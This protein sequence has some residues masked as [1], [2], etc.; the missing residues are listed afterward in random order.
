MIITIIVIGRIISEP[1]SRTRNNDVV[2]T[3]VSHNGGRP[4]DSADFH[5]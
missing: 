1:E 2:S 5:R 3:S 4:D